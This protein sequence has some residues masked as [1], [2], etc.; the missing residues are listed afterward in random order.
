MASLHTDDVEKLLQLLT[1]EEKV[2]LLAGADTWH[3]NEISRLGIG[4]LKT[5]D[6]PS[7]ARGQLAVDGPTAA[8][9][10][11]PIC[12]AATW[13][14]QQ[15][16]SVG[17]LLCEETKTKAAQILLAP[18]ICLSR[19]PLGGRNFESFGEDPFLTGSLATE[20]VAGV[21]E[22]GQVM[23]TV[24]HFVANEQEWQRFTIDAKVSEKAL[25]EMYLKPFE[26]VVRSNTTPGCL[27]TSYNVVNGAHADM[28]QHLLQDVLRGD[29]GFKGLVMSDWGGT[30]ST[31]ESVIAGLDLEM[32]G[33]PSKRGELLLEAV[34]KA[35]NPDE[36]LKAI[37]AS[38]GQILPMCKRMGLLGLSEEEA[39]QTRK[40]LEQS[41]TTQEGIKLMRTVAAQGA[42][43]L[44]NDKS[45]LPLKPAS[46]SGKQV[47]FI[48]PN[49]LVGTPG[50]GGSATMNPQ[51]LSQ[52]MS[53]FKAAVEAQ[54]LD[55][56]VVH[57]QG[58]YSKKWLPHFK[59]D[60][61]QSRTSGEDG[62]NLLRV[63]FYTTRDL[64]GPILET[65]HRNSS[66]V[67]FIDS[68]PLPLQKAHVPPYSFRVTSTVRPQTTGNHRFGVASVGE[69]RLFIDGELVLENCNWT[70]KSEAFFS[71]GSR[72]KI[73]SKHMNAGQTYDLVLEGW[74]KPG[75]SEEE[76]LHFF[77]GH[78]SVRIGFEEELPKN[79]IDA[80][81][82]TADQSDYSVVILGIDDEWESEGYDRQFMELPG[83]QNELAEALLTRCKYPERLIFINQSGSPVELPWEDK[84]STLVQAWYGGQEAG[85]GLADLLLGAINPSGRMPIS[86]PRKY[87]DLPY[88]ADKEMWP[89]V[90]GI[91]IYKEECHLG[92][93]YYL[94]NNVRPHFWFGFGLSYT[95]FESSVQLEVKN[96]DSWTFSTTVKNIGSTDGEETVQLYA[97]PS[98]KESERRLVAFDKTPLL[99]PGEET[100]LRLNVRK[101]DLASW[102]GGIDGQWVL[103]EGPWQFAVAKHA[104]DAEVKAIEVPVQSARTWK[105]SEW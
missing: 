75:L 58:A 40:R 77:A 86:W 51:Y 21:Q 79:M 80:A 17:R 27:M 67:D 94:Q 59:K 63:D 100:S 89:G 9:L 57:S 1:L 38:A 76:S 43:L 49:A 85:N 64:S 14:K 93:R 8:F 50:G 46:L 11:G 65:Q 104:G 60:Q 13:S 83:T 91:V 5:T 78:P 55:T 37:D 95:Q 97:W 33:P 22:T 12:Q 81:V 23:A 101:R 68:A 7:G 42:V 88:A 90:D 61:W 19:N 20:Y 45:T 92:Y 102:E 87:T 41:S 72:E 53:S 35:K 82:K 54:G 29:W 73:R 56:R 69:A 26:M 3:T 52:P 70:E 44:K 103:P 84:C 30:N 71:F 48:G 2:S 105:A 16:R 34:K 39:L 31:A 96:P 62:K 66:W 4:S 32:P 24:K 10:P 18:T 99:K 74:T 25:R 15:L 36:L 28:N 47:A 6:G 98:G